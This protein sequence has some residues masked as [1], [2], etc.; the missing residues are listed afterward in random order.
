MPLSTVEESGGQHSGAKAPCQRRSLAMACMVAA[1]KVE[2]VLRELLG[3]PSMNSVRRPGLATGTATPKKAATANAVSDRSAH[4]EGRRWRLR[5]SRRAKSRSGAR[6]AASSP[7]CCAKLPELAAPGIGPPRDG[8][9]GRSAAARWGATPASRLSRLP[10]QHLRQHQQQVVARMPQL[11]TVIR[12]GDLSRYERAPTTRVITA[13]SCVVR[14]VGVR[15]SEEARPAEGV[16]QESLIE[17]A[18]PGQAGNHPARHRCAVQR[19]RRKAHAMRRGDYT[20]M[21]SAAPARRAFGVSTFRTND[22]PNSSCVRLDP[23]GGARVSTAGASLRTGRP[24]DRG[25]S[26]WQS[27]RQGAHDCGY[28]DGCG[29]LTTATSKPGLSSGSSRGARAVTSGHQR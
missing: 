4:P 24:L 22:L 20:G 16:A 23:G 25:H 10:G 2:L 11:Q 7:P 14:C 12:A 26:R 18:W 29:V 8:P 13:D 28:Q 19:P 6:P 15:S 21:A 17:R 9:S 1:G 3:R 5:S 27:S